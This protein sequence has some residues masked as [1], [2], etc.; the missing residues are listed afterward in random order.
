[1]LTVFLRTI[2]LYALMVLV[3]RAMGK[4]QL[5]GF[6]PFELATTIVI[7]D[8][9]S[10]PMGEVSLPLLHGILPV[11]AL[12]IMQAVLS[13]LCVKSDRFRAILSGKPRVVISKGKINQKELSRLCIGVADLVEGIREAGILNPAECG[14]AVIEANGT[15]TAFPFSEKR[16]PTAAEIGAAPGYEGLPMVLIID[17]NVQS[18]N[19]MQTGRD[20][21]WLS[22]QLAPKNLLPE[23]V[24]FACL[25]TQG[26]M[27]V[28]PMEGDCFSFSALNASEVSW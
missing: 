12:F 25:D 11:A 15:I 23:N 28:Q 8:L 24:F 4:R 19:L 14:T 2:I 18:T 3:L 13:V 9:I 6:Q 17:G 22:A 16:P 1:M 10:T 21:Q 7:A 27:T 20:L 26:L 5:A